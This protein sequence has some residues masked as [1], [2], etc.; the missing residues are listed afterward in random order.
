MFPGQGI[1]VVD[2]PPFQPPEEGEELLFGIRD[3]PTSYMQVAPISTHE[4]YMMDMVDAMPEPQ[5]L[6]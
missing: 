5:Q 6:P 1:P 4:D 3:D 2:M